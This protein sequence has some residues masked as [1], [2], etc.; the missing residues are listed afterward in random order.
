MS[1][2]QLM[3]LLR[4][5][6]DR[7]TD[8]NAPRL[9]AALAYYT[10][11][12]LAPLLV[13]VVALCGIVFKQTAE[14]RLLQQ[15]Q[16]VAG[17][18][19]ARTVEMLLDSAHEPRSGI[20]ATAIA[21]VTLLFGASGVFV[22]LRDSLNTIWNAPRPSS[23]SV[24][25]FVWQRIISFGMVMAL[26]CLLFMS[27]A[28]SAFISI[29]ERFFSDLF[30]V[31]IA[32]LS[33]TA[34]FILSLAALSIL[35]GLIFKF[36]PNVPID[37]QDVGIGAVTT[38][39]LFSIGRG[40]LALYLSTLGVGST[41]GAAGSLVALVGWVYYSAQIFFFG[42]VFTKVYAD[43]CGSRAKR[44]RDL[45]AQGTS[46]DSKSERVNDND[47]AMDYVRLFEELARRKTLRTGAV[48][49]S[50]SSKHNHAGMT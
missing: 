17:V 49:G 16:Q 15:A 29:A 13:F 40:L 42:A 31:H 45:E 38:G 22:E 5:S 30:P 39:I 14:Q 7:W 27:I 36:V 33:E 44:G 34:N 20:T 1:G 4:T 21:F 47:K 10:L 46:E 18:V 37:W 25:R 35:F 23:Y 41:Y 11:L 19:G 6:A 3:F 12:S 26:G 28:L 43:C 9:G 24:W 50:S 2:R 32:I 8:H 48:K